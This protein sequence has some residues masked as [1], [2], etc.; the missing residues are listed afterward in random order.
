MRER[1]QSFT[2]GVVG[3]N[4]QGA[5]VLPYLKRQDTGNGTTTTNTT[6]TGGTSTGNSTT[7]GGGTNSTTPSNSTSSTNSTTSTGGG[8][9]ACTAVSSAQAGTVINPVMS[10]RLNT[11]GT[12]S[13]KYGKVEVRAKLPQ[14]DW[15]W[16]AIWMLPQSNDSS[17]AQGTGVY[18]GWPA[19][20]EIDV[21]QLVFSASHSMLTCSTQIMEARGN[22]PSYPSQGSNYVRSSMN[23][24]P[25]PSASTP[26]STGKPWFACVPSR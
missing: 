23:Y 10:G 3:V 25:F 17:A 5:F 4:D 11:R 7:S 18:G 15:L 14:G 6:D 22:L 12:K 16:P 21:C 19:S 13:I 1:P 9:N 8:T 24:G 20:G 26:I 2:D